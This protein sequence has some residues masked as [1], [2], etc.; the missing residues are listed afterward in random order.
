MSGKYDDIINLPHH[1]SSKRPQMSIHDRAAQFSPFAALTGYDGAV[2]ETARLTHKRMELNEDTL[3]I[4]DMKF[5]IILEHLKEEPVISLTYFVADERK[6]GGSY[7]TVTGRV[8]KAD[9]FKGQITLEGKGVI[10][11]GDII[12]IDGD[13]FNEFF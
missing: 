9:T 1:I 5:H 2:K 12:D 6:E 13:I 7:V 8:I 4:L 3:N 10:P 11:L